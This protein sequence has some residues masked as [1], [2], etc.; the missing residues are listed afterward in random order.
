[1]SAKAFEHVTDYD[2][3]ITHYFDKRINYRK[4]K[5]REMLKY[6]ANPYQSNA[7]ISSL[8]NNELPLEILSGRPG[9]INYLDAFQSW[10]LVSECS[11]KL[12]YVVAA[13]FKH[14]A[15]LA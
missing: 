12:G 1:M 6:G 8:D 11:N 9:Y 5:Q 14:T 13:S 10:L 7:F 4:H 15:L 3:H 2:I